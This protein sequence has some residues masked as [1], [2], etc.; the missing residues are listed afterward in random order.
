MNTTFG[1]FG[2]V[3]LPTHALPE[4]QVLVITARSFAFARRTDEGCAILAN[5]VSAHVIEDQGSE[6]RAKLPPPLQL[7]P[8]ISPWKNEKIEHSK[9]KGKFSPDI[10]GQ[11]LA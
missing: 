3:D 6:S 10:P 8:A 4:Y 7:R 9:I 2:E 11:G 5:C 1:K